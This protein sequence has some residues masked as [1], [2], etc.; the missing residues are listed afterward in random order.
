MNYTYADREGARSRAFE[1]IWAGLI[2]DVFADV[3]RYYDRANVF[4]TLGLLNRLRRGFI[5][6]MDVRPGERVLD[7]CAGTNVIG[8]DLLK[9][10]PTL[11]VHAIDRSRA[12]QQ[13]GAQSAA[14][15][16]L[17]IR[18]H[19]GDVHRLPFPDNHFDVVTLQFATRHLRA[20]Q[21]VREI[22]RVLKPGGRF[23]HC[24]MLRPASRVVEEA[25]CLYLAACVGLV[26]WAFRSAPAALACR[27]YF[28]DAI[29]LFYTTAEFSELLASHGFANVVGRPVLLGT[30]A[31]HRAAKP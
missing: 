11:E 16:G 9:R 10:E 22:H 1:A 29:R 27:R 12:M 25:Y 30:V 20:A 5:G 7:V 15:Q 23:Y 26:S 28:V 4:A 14:E 8:I 2:N 3:A 24:D 21:V 19:I 31:Y 13:V 6:T 18:S 17:A